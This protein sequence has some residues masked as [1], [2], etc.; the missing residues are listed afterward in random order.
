MKFAGDFVF[1]LTLIYS[2]ICLKSACASSVDRRLSFR[3]LG[4]PLS[5]IQS[6]NQSFIPAGDYDYLLSALDTM[7]YQYFNGCTWPTSIDW[8]AA[9]LQTY[10]ASSLISISSSTSY[11]VSSLGSN[12]LSGQANF[13]NSLVTRYF[14]Q[15]VNF[16]Y[17]Q[18]AQS[19]TTQKYDDMQWVVLGWLEA[20]KF[21]NVHTK[22]HYS[23]ASSATPSV[24]FSG[25]AYIRDFAHRARLF[26]DLASQGYST[27]LC[28]GG[29][30]WDSTD[31]PYKNAV[32]NELYVAASVGMYLYMPGDDNPSPSFVVNSSNSCLDPTAHSIT[33]G[34]NATASL[35]PVKARNP[36]YLQNAIKTFVWLTGINMTNSA[37]LYVDGFHLTNVTCNQRSEDVFSYNQGV[38]LSG[39]RGLWEATGNAS[40]LNY[41][42]S[43][44]HSTIG[45]TGY[46][47]GSCGVLG[48]KGV[49][50]DSCDSTGG[51]SQDDQTFKG[52]YFHHLMLFCAPLPY[53]STT[54]ILDTQHRQ[55]CSN[56]ERWIQSNAAAAF[57]TRN[58]TG[59]YGSSWAGSDEI[60]S[61]GR[62]RTVETQGGAVSVFNALYA[63]SSNSSG[64]SS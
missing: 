43:L 34:A 18:H 22:L 49:M 27:N 4:P 19:L 45:S 60:N 52:A 5:G 50:A 39:I 35:P 53:G 7:Q 12:T 30:V 56:Y 6:D 32:T 20:V 41:G 57:S 13:T 14:D 2:T 26:Y 11:S 17:A 15:L 36:K 29:M 28:G 24:N 21:V 8:T 55:L 44:I 23:S 64:S 48:C 31:T 42:H 46:Y 9:V 25:K 37:G 62:G 38:L 33:G 47:N 63:V 40:Y 16:Y 10:L 3:P 58:S 61:S 51:C 59:D 1:S 54:T